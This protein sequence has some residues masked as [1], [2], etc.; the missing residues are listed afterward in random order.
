MARNLSN[1]RC[2]RCQRTWTPS[3]IVG[4]VLVKLTHEELEALGVK[5]TFDCG[6]TLFLWVRADIDGTTHPRPGEVDVSYWHTFN[7]ACNPAK[8]FEVLD[9]RPVGIYFAAEDAPQEK[10]RG[11]LAHREAA[12]RK[13][14]ESGAERKNTAWPFDDNPYPV[15]WSATT[16]EYFRMT[17]CTDM[18]NCQTCL[19]FGQPYDFEEAAELEKVGYYLGETHPRYQ[20]DQ[21]VYFLGKDAQWHYAKILDSRWDHEGQTWKYAVVNLGKDFSGEKLVRKEGDL[22]NEK[23]DWVLVTEEEGDGGD[24]KAR[25]S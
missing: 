8:R 22:Y 21:L 14:L 25:P 19:M 4:K 20:E 23:P 9:P 18:P 10:I 15:F 6:I 3:D 13:Y 1:D 17:T 24:A 16:N 5:V 11:L 12:W 7:S 2:P